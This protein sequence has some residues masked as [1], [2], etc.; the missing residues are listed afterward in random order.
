MASLCKSQIPFSLSL[1]PFFSASTDTRSI[2]VSVS[3]IST[4]TLRFLSSFLIL[5]IFIV[6][7]SSLTLCIWPCIYLAISIWLS[8]CLSLSLCVRWPKESWKLFGV[9]A[10]T[11]L[12][13]FLWHLHK[14]GHTFLGHAK[15]QTSR[16][17]PLSMSTQ[18]RANCGPLRW[19]SEPH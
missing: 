12:F 19:L 9:T 6:D 13:F 14:F 4:S 15:L 2:S 5:T 8:V 3:L 17:W 7:D 10:S 1:H 16:L 18:P 11:T